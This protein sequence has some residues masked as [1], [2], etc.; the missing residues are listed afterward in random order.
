MKKR[1]EKIMEGQGEPSDIAYLENLGQTII[2]TS[3]CGLGHTSPNAMLSSMAN[4]PLV[5]AALLKEHPDGMQSSFNIQQALDESRRIA[6]RR[7]LI[8]D[9]SYG[10]NTPE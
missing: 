2:A 3:R 7:S 10:N 4:F 5:Y 8:Y 9:P 1:L 6:K